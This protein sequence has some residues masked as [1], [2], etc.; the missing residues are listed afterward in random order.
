VFFKNKMF[1][2]PIFRPHGCYSE[3]RA[4]PYGATGLVASLVRRSDPLPPAPKPWLPPLDV[5]AYCD[6]LRR[7]GCDPTEYERLAADFKWP[8]RPPGKAPLP[9]LNLAPLEKLFYGAREAPRLPDYFKALRQCG[10][11]E[12]TVA[13]C[14]AY[15]KRLEETSDQRQEALD[16]IF[17]RWPSAGKPAKKVIKAVKKKMVR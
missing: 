7:H 1:K 2:R 12:E 5:E 9:V 11:P 4:V 8:E 17:A 3:P 13:K 6:A 16:L 15:F 14:V 10:Y